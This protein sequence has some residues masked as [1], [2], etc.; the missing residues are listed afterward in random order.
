[1][2]SLCKLMSPRFETC[3]HDNETTSDRYRGKEILSFRQ[4]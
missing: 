1:M 3:K 2:R 4:A